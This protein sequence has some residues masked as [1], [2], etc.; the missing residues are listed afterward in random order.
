MEER[1]T[2]TTRP[3]R[4]QSFLQSSIMPVH[5]LR[6]NGATADWCQDLAQRIA[7]HSPRG[8]G[9]PGANVDNDSE[10]RVPSA[11]LWNLTKPPMFNV[12][13]RGNS[14]QQHEEKF[15]TLAENLQLIGARD[16]A[17]LEEKRLTWTTL[18]YSSRRSVGRILLL[19]LMSR[20]LTSSKGSQIR[21]RRS[22]SRQH[23]F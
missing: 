22:C 16:D 11:D 8:T 14:V 12:G 7:A 13:A 15:E 10:S 5:Q 21:T 20:A 6:I 4:R 19:E 17:W 18:R 9:N 1:R 2:T 3:R 23:Q